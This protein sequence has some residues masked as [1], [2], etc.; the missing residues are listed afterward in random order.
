MTWHD[1][2]GPM[3]Y[4][5][6][7][8]LGY[9]MHI[10]QIKCI[11]YT[12]SLYIQCGLFDPSQCLLSMSELLPLPVS[13]AGKDL[14]GWSCTSSYPSHVLCSQLSITKCL[15]QFSHVWLSLHCLRMYVWC[16]WCHG[17]T[18]S[19][20][21]FRRTLILY[22]YHLLHSSAPWP[23]FPP[24]PMVFVEWPCLLLW[25]RNMQQWLQMQINNWFKK[26]SNS[27]HVHA[28]NQSIQR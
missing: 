23:P 4:P 19:T 7:K 12:N 22:S 20:S 6:Y 11:R 26:H 28:G 9:L 16:H 14:W 2:H 10:Q 8:L 3:G 21:H 13:S 27:H 25:E 1:R 17:V 24:S 5:V 15:N 18:C